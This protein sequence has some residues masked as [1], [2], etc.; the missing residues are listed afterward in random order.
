MQE[1]E[2]NSAIYKIT[3][4]VNNKCYIG[5]AVDVYTRLAV[6]KSGLKYGKQPNKHLQS[7]YDKYGIENF[8]FEVLEYVLDK[9]DLLKR[10][11]IWINY[12]QSCD[13]RF[14][15]NKRQ[16]P[17]SNLGVRRPHSEETKLKI[18]LANS[19]ALLGKTHS[20][21]TKLKMSLAKK[22]KPK[23]EQA[24]ANMKA[25]WARKKRQ[26]NNGWSSTWL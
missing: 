12:F 26:L 3:N 7:A 9:V 25:A 6:H 23:S 17:N 8:K 1:I 10:E 19:K 24:K 15:Y 13:R 16:I 22:G 2:F 21:V 11:Q 18:G 5:S 20:E 14:G 4:V